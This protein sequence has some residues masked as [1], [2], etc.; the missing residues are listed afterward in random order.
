MAEYNSRHTGEQI[1]DAIDDV[2]NKQDALVS[3]INIKTIN[4]ESVLGSGNI[5]IHGGDGNVKVCSA[6][7][8]A[9]ASLSS[10]AQTKL[11]LN[12][13]I[14]NSDTN[15]F[16]LYNGGIR[17]LK[18]GTV[19]VSGA[20]YQTTTASALMGAYIFMNSNEK[21]NNY[22]YMGGSGSST[23]NVAVSYVEVSAG[24]VFYLY[25]RNSASKGTAY[26]GNVAT[27]LSVSY[28][29]TSDEEP[30]GGSTDWDDI[31]NKPDTFPPEA[32]THT[33]T[34]IGGESAEGSLQI[35]NV[36]IEWGTFPMS[37][38]SRVGTGTNPYTYSYDINFSESFSSPPAIS[39][40]FRG[41]Y[42]NVTRIV[43]YSSAVD[44]V[45]AYVH[46]T[47]QTTT[48]S[49]CWIAIGNI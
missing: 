24:D 36:L 15:S 8:N 29:S 48:G 28:V 47:A 6:R 44:K 2:A 7:G 4:G 12:T 39:F 26:V 46:R 33:I 21:T 1:D 41:N 49:V 40:T 38:A 3:G 43:A 35:G 34:D 18:N 30:A 25:G 16:D 19:A 9:N 13:L 45:I 37:D 23:S 32:H 14:V 20:L 17:C 42:T 11:T 5:E 22:V 10:S 27:H 31:Q